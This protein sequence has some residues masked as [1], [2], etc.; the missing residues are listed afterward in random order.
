MKLLLASVDFPPR[1]GGVA[2]VCHQF[3]VALAEA[4]ADVSVLALPGA[5]N[6]EP[7]SDVYQLYTENVSGL[8]TYWGPDW[9]Q[10]E[11]PLAIDR[12]RSLIETLAPDRL[13]ALHPHYYGQTFSRISRER[14]VPVS[15]LAHGFEV[16]EHLQDVSW[17]KAL[18][19]RFSTP[20]PTLK[21]EL[22]QSFANAEEVMTNS[23]FTASLVRRLSA[24]TKPQVIGCGLPRHGK[25]GFDFKPAAAL[26]ASARAHLG[27]SSNSRIVGTV[28]RLV[29]SKG[30]DTLIKA[31]ARCPDI[32]CL[33]V[34]DGPEKKALEDLA[35][36]LEL[37]SRVHFLGATDDATKAEAMRAMDVF[38]LLSHPCPKGGV[39]GFGIVFLEALAEGTPVIATNFGGIPDVVKHDST[40]LLVAPNSPEHAAEAISVM[41]SNPDFAVKTVERGRASIQET[42]RWDKIAESSLERWQRT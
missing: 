42:F 40:G 31:V 37:T 18:W 15:I 29:K 23:H 7:A 16:N 30:I 2:T 26:Q 33:I 28:C 12:H 5:E 4:G 17:L 1:I 38:L 32:E 19:Q 21:D 22:Q 34:G 39:E 36:T 20:R 6:P 25:D 8:T 24:S 35:E 13:V 11:L 9:L 27:L 41:L 3:A 10:S 14:G